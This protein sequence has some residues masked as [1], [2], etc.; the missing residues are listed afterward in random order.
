MLEAYVQQWV[1]WADDDDND[2]YI[3]LILGYDTNVTQNTIVGV[4]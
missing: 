2:F 4:P 1:G 3:Q